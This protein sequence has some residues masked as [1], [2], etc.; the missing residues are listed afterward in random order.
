MAALYSE[1]L[2]TVFTR[3]NRE[4]NFSLISGQEA[5]PNIVNATN[6]YNYRAQLLISIS[7]AENAISE[8][9]DLVSSQAACDRGTYIR[10]NQSLFF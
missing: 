4:F 5:S 6:Y 1:S 2:T 8:A 3:Y 10:E 7:D 9:A